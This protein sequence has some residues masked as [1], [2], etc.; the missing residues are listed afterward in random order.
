MV[1]ASIPESEGADDALEHERITLSFRAMGG[2]LW[3][4]DIEA[5]VLYCNARWYEILGLDP[6]LTPVTSLQALKPHVHPDDVDAATSIDLGGVKALFE[7]DECYRVEFRVVR[8]DGEVRWLRSVACI[9]RDSATDHM[10]AIGCVTDI[11]EFRPEGAMHQAG[12]HSFET[13]A[14]G[15]MSERESA[16]DPEPDAANPLSLKEREC[17]RWVSVGKTAWETAKILGVS[18]RTV[19]FHLHNATH[20]LDAGNKVQ[21]AFIAV[22]R[23]LLDEA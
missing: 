13:L 18:P 23:R 8:P 20:K 7:R 21:A 12:A 17:L 3:D 22:R 11:S 14:P 2:G 10:R 5:D 19:E 9:I 4:Y 15:P 16:T 1:E 6:T